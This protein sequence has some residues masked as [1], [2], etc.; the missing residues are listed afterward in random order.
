MDK[1]QQL[2]SELP[3]QLREPTRAALSRLSKS[4][5]RVY[6][7]DILHWL[8]YC[9][10][11]KIELL[12][13]TRPQVDLYCAALSKGLKPAT[14]NRHMSAISAWFS[15]L[16]ECEIAERNPFKG[17]KRPR[18]DKTTSTTPWLSREECK[19]LLEAAEAQTGPQAQRDAAIMWLLVTEGVRVAEVAEL[20]QSSLRVTGGQRVIRVRGKGNVME[21]RALPGR[22]AAQLDAYLAAH[23]HTG[24]LFVTST[25][26]KL[27]PSYISKL[28]ARFANAAG[29]PNPQQYTAHSLRHTSATIAKAEGATEEE[30]SKGLGHSSLETTR[31]YLHNPA[32]DPAHR[33]EQALR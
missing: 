11:K 26:N 17:P 25:G 19:R 28:V 20:M 22:L 32:D 16:V 7:G 23:P 30:I 33:V 2:L 9:A 29:L 27:S 4:S 3:E 14:V 24:H 21:D 8:G 31:G 10:A 12:T 13:P 6:A 1:Q 15:Y 5:V 18:V